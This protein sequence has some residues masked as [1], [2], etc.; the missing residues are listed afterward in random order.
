M[1]TMRSRPTR[2]RRGGV[3]T[4][5]ADDLDPPAD[6]LAFAIEDPAAPPVR[7]EVMR[8]VVHVA[9]WLDPP[10]QHH[11][12][13]QFRMWA[14][15]PAGLRHPRM[16]TGHLMRVQSVCLGWH[17]YPYTYSRT[18]D[19]TDGAPVKPLPDDLAELARAAVAETFG[20]GYAPDAAIVNLYSPGA[21]L[22][23]HQ[24]GEEPSDAPVV[25]L[26]LGDTCTFRLAGV[27]RRTGPFADVLL[28]SGDLLVFGGPSRR[29]YHGVP[30][31]LAGTGPQLGLPPGR[32]SI[33]VRET[34]L[35]SA[36]PQ[37]T[38][39]VRG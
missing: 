27:E 30:R 12:A 37:S 35:G 31:V 28:R 36:A 7:H 26:S 16:P 10:T 14:Q 34:G 9:G 39:A 22:G 6:Q 2:S 17:W 3:P 11:L 18:A 1:G 15:P 23:L 32:L 38:A 25:T 19:D 29:I 21:H 5:P 8:G 13:L 20:V 33:T 24:D 4:T